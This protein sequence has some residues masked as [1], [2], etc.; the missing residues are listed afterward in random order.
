MKIDNHLCE[1]HQ[2]FIHLPSVS[3]Q[4]TEPFGS[5]KHGGIPQ[6]PKCGLEAQCYELF[7]VPKEGQTQL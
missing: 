4:S 7:A 2:G 3:G 1:L 5:S 6:P